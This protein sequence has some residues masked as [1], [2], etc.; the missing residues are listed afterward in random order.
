MR[1]RLL[2]PFLAKGGV[3]VPHHKNT[4]NLQS[5]VM[6]PP[7]QVVIPML[8]HIGAPCKPTVKAGDKVLVGQVIGDTEAYMAAPVHASVSGTVKE[9]TSILMPS[10][11]P[12]EAVVIESDGRMEKADCAP[13][14]VGTKENFLKAVRASGLVGLGG[15][16]FPAHVKLNVPPDKEVDTLIVNA[17]ECEPYIT[18]DHREILENSWSV[19]SGVY[20]VKE[21]LGIQRVIIAIENNKPDAIQ[22]LSEIAGKEYDPKNEVRVMA[23]KSVYPQGAEKILI[24][25]CTGRKVPPGKLPADVGCIVMNVTSVA[26]LAQYLKTGLPLVS[27]RITVDG[28]AVQNPQNVIVPIGTSVS[29]VIGFCGGYKETP[30]K[31]LYGGPMMGTALSDDRFPVLKQNNAVLAFGE[32]EAKLKEPSACIRCGC[33]MYVC[34]MNLLPV[35]L[36]QASEA[37][38]M[39]KLEKYR[40]MTCIECGCCSYVCPANRHILQAIRLGKQYYKEHGKAGK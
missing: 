12:V 6:P 33:C 17:A 34:P 24:R 3:R 18:S 21:L 20:A 2:K 35:S 38:D 37:K 13:P 9:I 14:D 32:K 4:A 1:E 40:V 15:A 29:D 11:A 10:G 36:A 23:L 39:D 5:V 16:G 7:K 31:I 27:K 8:Q 19:L 26:F 25:S 30:K 22:L 28:S